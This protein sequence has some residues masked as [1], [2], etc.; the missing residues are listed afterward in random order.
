MIEKD[1]PFG[2]VKEIDP[3]GK[4]VYFDSNENISSSKHP[5]LMQFRD[6]FSEI[7]K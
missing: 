6:A 7:I 4:I 5:Y 1:L 3:K 2:W